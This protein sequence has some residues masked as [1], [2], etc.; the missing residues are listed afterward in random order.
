[1]F[2][3]AVAGIAAYLFFPASSRAI[4]KTTTAVS[5]SD[6]VRRVRGRTPAFAREQRDREVS[7]VTDL[8]LALSAELRA[9][10]PPAVA[11]SRLWGR[12][13]VATDGGL[14]VGLDG[15]DIPAVLRAA[16]V[17]SG[18]SGLARVAVCWDVAEQSGAGLAPALERVVQSL[19]A[20]REI[21]AEVEG[22]LAGSRATARLLVVLPVFALILGE[23]LGAQP[24]RVLCTTGYGWGCLLLGL[25]LSFVG[26]RWIEQQVRSVSPWNDR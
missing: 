13:F 19:R 16:A 14:R 6:V 26:S 3:A 21:A 4:S 11:W 9:G 5:W 7:Q 18:R 2:A 10:Q 24:V 1:M 23:S 12:S 22:Q 20:E 17:G 15:A 25:A 8:I